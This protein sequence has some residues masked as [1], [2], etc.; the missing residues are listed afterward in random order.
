M[1]NNST[2]L[3]LADETPYG[4]TPTLWIAIMFVVLFSISTLAQLIQGLYARHWFILPTIVLGGCGEI[5]GWAARW[6]SN[7][8]PNNGEPFTIQ[9]AT[10]IISPTP[11]LGAHFIIFGRLVQI[12]GPQYSRFRPRLYSRIFL[13]CDVASLVV[14]AVGG[15]IAS[16]AVTT[17]ESRLGSNIMLAGIAIQFI[18]L[19]CFMSIA[20]EFLYRFNRNLPMR[21]ESGNKI[22][23]LDTRRRIGLLAVFFATS[24][25]FIRAIYRLVELGDGWQGKVIHTQWLFD[26]FD[27]TMVTLV[28]YTWNFVPSSW[29]LAEPS[30]E[31][32]QLQQIEMHR[33]GG[34]SDNTSNA[35]NKPSNL[36]F[37]QRN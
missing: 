19:I 21:F 15:G 7:R 33:N 4:Y 24:C 5:L 22:G 12:L 6:W 14:Q 3:N 27:S 35:S 9:I 16:S 1:S 8:N 13:S 36:V 29:I 34:S 26:L 31:S 2:T 25:L 20:S 17:Q 10:L 32:R 37:Y 11:I 30:L 28:M 23:Y 18:I